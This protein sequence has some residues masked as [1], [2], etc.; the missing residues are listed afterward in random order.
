MK[1]MHP[2]AKVGLGLCL[3]AILWVVVRSQI[4]ASESADW[5]QISDARAAGF[6]IEALENARAEVEGTDVE[7]WCSF[8]LAME[9]YA[10]GE[11]LDR[12][13]QVATASVSKFADHA[14]API[15]AE[16]L[17]ALQSYSDI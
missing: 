5:T 9:L 4:A 12:A 6:T 15:L 8:Y 2:W 16:L 13:Q 11:D 3:A 10:Q 14:T 17:A 7:P 1:D